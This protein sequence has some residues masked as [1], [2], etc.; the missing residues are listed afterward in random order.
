MLRNYLPIYEV[1]HSLGALKHDAELL[2]GSGGFSSAVLL[3][4]RDSLDDLLAAIARVCPEH[5]LTYTAELAAHISARTPPKTYVELFPVLS[6]LNDTLTTELEKEAIFR[7]PPERKDFYEQNDLFGPK[8]HDAFPS[9]RRDIQKAG[10]CYALGQEDAC[11]HHLMLVLERGLNTLASV[12]GVP[13]QS[14]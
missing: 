7:I 13:Y 6:G 10:N 2:V 9:C 3:S 8:A 1:A 11:V 5:G 14:H 4:D 12:V